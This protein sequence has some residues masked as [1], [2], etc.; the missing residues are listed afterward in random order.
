MSLKFWA[1]G[2]SFDVK[3]ASRIEQLKG[4]SSERKPFADVFISSYSFWPFRLAI[5]DFTDLNLGEHPMHS[6]A[7]R[8]KGEHKRIGEDRIDDRQEN[9]LKEFMSSSHKGKEWLRESNSYDRMQFRKKKY[10]KYRRQHNF[11][12]PTAS[13]I[14][15]SSSNYAA[16]T[17]SQSQRK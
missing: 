11:H 1:S 17:Q 8:S 3:L 12:F 14:R 5:E 10:L 7:N 6:K 16:S 9:S 4:L 15:I 13:K 2:F